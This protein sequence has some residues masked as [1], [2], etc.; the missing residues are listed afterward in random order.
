LKNPIDG[1]GKLKYGTIELER[2]FDPLDLSRDQLKSWNSIK[3]HLLDEVVGNF[4]SM[5]NSNLKSAMNNF[6]AANVFDGA[7]GSIRVQTFVLAE[8]KAHSSV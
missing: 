7:E 8:A 4:G 3:P 1:I 2:I 5:T 6:G